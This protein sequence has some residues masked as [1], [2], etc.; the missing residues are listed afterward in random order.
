[1]ELIGQQ[2]ASDTV[3]I[4]GLASYIIST[5][6]KLC[7]PVRDEEVKGLQEARGNVVTLFK[8]AL[9]VTSLFTDCE[10]PQVFNCN[11]TTMTWLILERSSNGPIVTH[12]D[13]TAYHWRV[14]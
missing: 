3:D 4:Q 11:I 10:E 12:P 1:M 13:G 8:Y 2:A 14:C 5:M 6:G 7:A 9:H